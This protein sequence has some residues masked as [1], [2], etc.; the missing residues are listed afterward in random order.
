MAPTFDTAAG[1]SVAGP[2]SLTYSHTCTGTNLILVVDVAF[3]NMAIGGTR[4]VSY[5]KGGL[6]VNL[7]SQGTQA[8]GGGTAGWIERFLMI[9]PDTGTHTVSVA[10]TGGSPAHIIAGSTSWAA[11]DQVTGLGPQTVA[12]S[13]QTGVTSGSIIKS[14]TTSGNVVLTCVTEGSDA[15]AFTAGT[16]RYNSA[17]GGSGAAGDVCIA[18]SPSTGSAVTVSWTQNSDWWGAL[19]C[20]VLAVGAGAAGILPQQSKHRA[21]AYFTRL[22]SRNRGGVYSR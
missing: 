18:S 2:T 1:N 13:G 8:S 17:L 5:T 10:I 4:T 12:N 3:D 15:L 9:A 14:S 19:T 20:E 16:Q 6:T 21:P 22:N 7:I 11:A